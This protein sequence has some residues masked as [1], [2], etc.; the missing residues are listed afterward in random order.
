[1]NIIHTEKAPAVV[2]PY[3]QAISHNGLL[4]SA[5]QIAIDPQIG[6]L[7]E[8][9]IIAQTIQVCKNLDAVLTAW[10]SSK[11]QVIKTT[12]FLQDMNDYAQMNEVYAEYF[13]DHAPA[14]S[15]VEV[16]R[17]PLDAKVEIEVIAVV[18]E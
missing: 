9:D 15:A 6:R 5:G 14:R 18:S 7:I 12:V 11:S 3:S 17:L 8:W 2:W 4:Y 16:A 13:W 10:N 1:M